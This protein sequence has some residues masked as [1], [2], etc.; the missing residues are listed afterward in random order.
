M[1]SR[2]RWDQ[3]AA[4][5]RK[6]PRKNSTPREL[7]ASSSSSWQLQGSNSI[8]RR[9]PCVYYYY[10]YYSY[11][12]YYERTAHVDEALLSVRTQQRKTIPSQAIALNLKCVVI[13]NGSSFSSYKVNGKCLSI[14][15][16]LFTFKENPGA[17]SENYLN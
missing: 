4:R 8:V 2:L 16:I 10:Y 11:Y 7:S 6:T 14:C 17:F 3:T 5:Q 9:R 15:V 13:L 1:D 12:F